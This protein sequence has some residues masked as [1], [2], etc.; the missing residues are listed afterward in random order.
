[1]QRF[2]VAWFIT[3]CHWFNSAE[4]ISHTGENFR[5]SLLISAAAETLLEQSS[6]AR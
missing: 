3:S 4:G 1:M 2:S 5:C 6:S